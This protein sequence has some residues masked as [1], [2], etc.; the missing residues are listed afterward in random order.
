MSH[1]R[2]VNIRETC[3][4]F[5]Q[6]WKKNESVVSELFYQKFCTFLEYFLLVIF[7]SHFSRSSFKFEIFFDGFET[8]EIFDPKENSQ[9]QYIICECRRDESFKF[10]T[11]KENCSEDWMSFG[12]KIF[13][14]IF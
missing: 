2:F 6:K 4:I 12:Q 13:C 14:S 8:I 10:L 3:L 9:I 5:P 1:L 7:S 11:I